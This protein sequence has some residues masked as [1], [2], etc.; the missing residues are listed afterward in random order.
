[1]GETQVLKHCVRLCVEH[2]HAPS[3][4]PDLF[5]PPLK[6]RRTVLTCTCIEG[7]EEHAEGPRNFQT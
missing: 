5:S 4:V 3:F 6:S 2:S 1:M 7:L